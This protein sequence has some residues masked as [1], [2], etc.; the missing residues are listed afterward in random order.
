M[1]SAIE[2]KDLILLG[3]GGVLGY[4]PSLLVAKQTE[5]KKNLILEVV[6][7]EIVVERTPD[8]PF[9]ITASSGEQLDSVYFFVTRVWNKGSEVVRGD[10][11]SQAAPLTIEIGDSVR[12]LGEPQ[13]IKPHAEMEF[14]ITEVTKNKF[15]ISFDCLNQDEWVQIGFFVTGDPRAP[16]KGSGRVFGQHLEFDITTDDSK[17]HWGERLMSLLA[18]LLVVTSPIT[19]GSAIWWAYKDYQLIDLVSNQEN[20]PRLLQIM[21]AQ[22]IFVPVLSAL[23]FG[24]LWLKRKA[25]P[26]GY[27]IR[28][29]F[30]PSQWQSL[31]AFL[32][33]ALT[34][35]RYQ[36][37]T[38]VYDY[39]E[40]KPRASG[41]SP[42]P[43]K[44]QMP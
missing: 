28:E 23:Y 20:L 13:V 16:I 34:G 4:L 43:E 2:S 1:L 27:P 14:C 9:S 11:I 40:I 24:S 6:G 31:R 8:C 18:F 35:K 3:A 29:D 41:R 22:G 38:S 39:G 25:N 12:L 7:R 33:T 15:T 10:E 36:V 37:S 32:L 5:K 42:Q 26:K 44:V 19:L 17:A 21:F 30:E